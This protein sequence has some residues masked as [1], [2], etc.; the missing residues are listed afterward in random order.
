MARKRKY[1]IADALAATIEIRS[2]VHVDLHELATGMNVEREHGTVLGRVTNVTH[3]DPILTARI[4][5]AHLTEHPDYYKR[6]LKAGL[7]DRSEVAAKP[8]K[9]HIRR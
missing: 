8:R 1:T 5:L 6:L 3:D 7:M 9:R 4:A 2:S